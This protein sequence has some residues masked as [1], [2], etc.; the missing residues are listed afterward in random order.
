MANGLLLKKPWILKKLFLKTRLLL[1]ILKERFLGKLLDNQIS[2][3]DQ[4]VQILS[5][6]EGETADKILKISDKFFDSIEDPEQMP[7]TK[8]SRQK[9][10]R[11]HPDSRW[12][13]LHNG[14]PVS[15]IVI[16]PTTKV[17]MRQFLDGAINER[18]LLNLSEPQK[19]YDALYLAVAFTVPEERGHG[20]SKD[21]F[22][23]AFQR[24]P[25]TEDAALFCW[26]VSDEGSGLAESLAKE[27]GKEIFIKK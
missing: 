22:R 18:Q 14:E 15:W 1:T 25:H 3:Q 9:L 17:L 8:E 16:M 19:M 7:A 13:R 6:Q 10:Q 4:D 23:R 24:I 27:L 26:P 2:M 20:Y 12:C 11:L 5:N 21:L